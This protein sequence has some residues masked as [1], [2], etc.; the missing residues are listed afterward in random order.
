MF[1]T[2]E[3]GIGESSILNIASLMNGGIRPNQGGRVALLVKNPRIKAILLEVHLPVVSSH[4]P[5][6]ACDRLGAGNSF[7]EFLSGNTI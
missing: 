4:G 2:T 1:L 6:L 3:L 7:F 5:Q